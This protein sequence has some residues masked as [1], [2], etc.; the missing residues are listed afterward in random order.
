MSTKSPWFFDYDIDTS[1]LKK[2]AA[3]RTDAPLQ[4]TNNH[5]GL[6]NM[7]KICVFSGAYKNFFHDGSPNFLIKMKSFNTSLYFHEAFL[8]LTLFNRAEKVGGVELHVVFLFYHKDLL[9]Y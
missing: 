3:D 5:L 4:M 8:F 6:R 9:Y 7:M 2:K 1:F